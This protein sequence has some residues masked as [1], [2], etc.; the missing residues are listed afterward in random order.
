MKERSNIDEKGRVT[1]IGSPAG[2]G[3]GP[4]SRHGPAQGLVCRPSRESGCERPMA[5]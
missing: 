3:A 1:G 2:V 5:G 4:S